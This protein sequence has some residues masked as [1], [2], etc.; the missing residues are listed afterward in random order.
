MDVDVRLL[1]NGVMV[2]DVAWATG[3]GELV[4]MATGMVGGIVPGTGGVVW[5]IPRTP[6]GDVMPGL[7][8]N[9]PV[10][11]WA[12]NPAAV[13]VVLLVLKR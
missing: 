12:P 13:R 4:T 11:G 8:C 6:L 10:E 2:G 1:V 5:P 9:L 3:Q 7:A